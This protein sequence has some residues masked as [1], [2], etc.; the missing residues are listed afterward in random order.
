MED[1]ESRDHPCPDGR[2][3]DDFE[4]LARGPGYLAV[5]KPAGLP[6]H[7]TARYLNN[8]LTGVMF[9]GAIYF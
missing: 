7:P 4:E 1:G 8:T 5:D 6:V 2:L 9:Y 3:D